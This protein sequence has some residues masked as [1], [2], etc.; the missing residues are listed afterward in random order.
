MTGRNGNAWLS[1]LGCMMFSL[2]VRLKVNS[3]LG[4]RLPYLQHIAS[5]AVVEAVRSL[6]GYKVV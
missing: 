2:M 5:L 6:A 1:P 3:E 4:A